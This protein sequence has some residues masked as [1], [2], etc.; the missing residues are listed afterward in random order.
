MDFFSQIC[1]IISKFNT[2]LYIKKLIDDINSTSSSSSGLQFHQL[3]HQIHQT[4][5]LLPSKEYS[6]TGPQV[7]FNNANSSNILS[8]SS[9]SAFA[10]MSS[11]GT[12]LAA[13]AV[14]H[15]TGTTSHLA[16][17]SHS[18][19]EPA[20]LRIIETRIDAN[21]IISQIELELANR[22]NNQK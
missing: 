3:Q 11:T 17:H 8:S 14:Q 6:P 9:S 19:I 16:Y 22:L 15:D 13:K 20:N 12:S 18:K 21:E 10:T 2:N 4:P 7:N 1:W 5:L